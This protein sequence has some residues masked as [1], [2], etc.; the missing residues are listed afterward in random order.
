MSAT[1]GVDFARKA[2]VRRLNLVDGRQLTG[3]H[4]GHQGTVNGQALLSGNAAVEIAVRKGLTLSQFG[5]TVAHETMHAFLFERGFHNLD[6]PS[7]EGMCEVLAHEWLRRRPGRLD[8][9]EE[10]RTTRNQDPVYGT[11]YRTARA[12][13][14]RLGVMET[15]RVL[16]RTGRIPAGP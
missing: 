7:E 15:L 14:E 2:T 5:A 10:L 4:P 16:R 6:L 8:R 12:A 9:Y 3:S 11:G 1:F 13:V